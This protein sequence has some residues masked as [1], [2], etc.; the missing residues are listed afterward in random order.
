MKLRTVN[1]LFCV[2]L[3]M[4]QMMCILFCFRYLFFYLLCA[5][6][7]QL[8]LESGNH[9]SGQSTWSICH[10]RAMSRQTPP[11]ELLLLPFFISS[12]IF[13]SW[14]QLYPYLY[15]CGKLCFKSWIQLYPYLYMCGKLCFEPVMLLEAISNNF[16]NICD[17]WLLLLFEC[18]CW[19]CHEIP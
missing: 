2:F 5:P 17:Y 4:W 3:C 11:A 7:E 12:R 6:S 13:K 16:T 1:Y 18:C 14:I 15:M 8:A 19:G 9:T 10:G